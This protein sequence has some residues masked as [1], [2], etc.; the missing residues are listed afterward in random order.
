MDAEW[1]DRS[2]GAGRRERK[3]RVNASRGVPWGR[4]RRCLLWRC[5]LKGPH[6]LPFPNPRSGRALPTS[7]HQ[8]VVLPARQY[9]FQIRAN[10]IH[11]KTGGT[12]INKTSQS[13][14]TQ[15]ARTEL[16]CFWL[17]SGFYSDQPE[18]VG[19][20]T[21]P[22]QVRTVM[23]GNFLRL[24]AALQVVSSNCLLVHL[25]LTI[26]YKLQVSNGQE[27]HTELGGL[28]TLTAFYCP[29]IFFFAFSLQLGAFKIKKTKPQNHARAICGMIINVPLCF[30]RC[31]AGGEGPLWFKIV[32]P[33][34]PPSCAAKKY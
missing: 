2:D 24:V 26:V 1:W 30:S 18:C 17:H 34:R 13:V 11:P 9:A 20:L 31:V 5:L 29:L 8:Q 27:K 25:P 6:V 15:L 7:R 14:C 3:K 33:A 19:M 4:R 21:E 28:R 22:R 10:R 23:C 12:V 32:L 16:L